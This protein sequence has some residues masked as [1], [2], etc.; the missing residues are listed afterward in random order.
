MQYEPIKRSL[1]KFFA[2]SPFLRKTLY[3]LLDLLLLR[4]WHVKKALRKIA[5]Q[6]PAE[7]SVLDAGSGFGQY[8][9][10]MSR[11]NR[12]WKVRAVD[13]NQEQ[14]DDCNT[15]FR[16][17]G[18]SDRVT[19]HSCDLTTLNESNCYD[20]VLSVDV[21]EHI[22]E[23]IVV[24][25][26]FYKSLK[27]NGILLISTPSDKGGS[28]VH[29]DQEESFIDE[30]VRDGYGIKEITE[31]LSLSG[32]RN[33]EASYTYGKPGNISWRLSMKYPVKMLNTSYLF[34]LLLPFY[35]I[36]FFPVSIILN[37]FDLFLTHKTGTGLLVTARKQE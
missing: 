37:I 6:F 5:L 14:I 36:L 9:W 34:F 22:E 12:K 20:I 3:F 18:L 29:S 16:K 27:N 26:N 35:Y 24:F 8:T 19:F 1:G 11:M 25:Q 17:T 31:K 28:D 2:G 13:I 30:H 23:D 7:A 4:T 15:F 32:F 33:I 10:R 21:M